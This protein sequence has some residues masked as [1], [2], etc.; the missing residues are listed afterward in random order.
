MFVDESRFLLH[1]VDSRV[2]MRRLLGE[3]LQNDCVMFNQTSGEGSV[4]VWGVF[5]HCGASD[6]VVLGWNVTGMLYRD[7]LDQNLIPFARQHFED[8]FRY[9]DDNAPAHRA[10]VVRQFLEQEQI[11]TLYETPLSPDC[12]PTEHLWDALQKAVDARDVMPQDLRE[13]SQSLQEECRNM[14]ED[15]LRNLAD[16]IPQR[17][18]A[19]A[20]A[21]GGHTNY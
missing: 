15:T 19:V 17:I 10:R 7:I 13:L 18:A 3:A 8:K 9:Q 6:L 2:R 16:S 12:N 5:H 21:R 1:R 14:G 4:R 20:R 11:H